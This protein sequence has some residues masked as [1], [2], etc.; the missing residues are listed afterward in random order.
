MEDVGLDISTKMNRASFLSRILILYFAFVATGCSDSKD[1]R[2]DFV[3]AACADVEA[4]QANQS[5]NPDLTLTVNVDNAVAAANHQLGGIGWNAGSLESVQPLRPTFVRVDSNLSSV[6]PSKGSELQLDSLLQKITR[7]RKLGAEPLVILY[8]I[9]AWM[10]EGRAADCTIQ[11]FGGD[12]DPTRVAP[13]D[14][15]EWEDFITRVVRTLATAPDNAVFFEVWNEPDLAFAF[16]QD[17]PQAFLETALRTHRAVERV[18]QE[19]GIDLKIGGPALSGEFQDVFEAVSLEDYVSA[20]TEE[21]L[22][23]DFISWHHYA[24]SPLLGPDGNEGFVDDQL[25]S[26]LSGLNPNT[27]PSVY[28]EMIHDY[29]QRVTALLPQS[30]PIPDLVISEW[31]ISSG[32]LDLRHDT[33]EGA[34]FVTASLIEME[35]ADL[36]SAIIYRGV[37][38]NSPGD[39]GLVR[40]DGSKKPSWHVMHAW[41]QIEGQRL[42]VDG[43]N[44]AAGIWARVVRQGQEIHVLLANFLA[45]EGESS[46]V[47][48]ALQGNCRPRNGCVSLIDSTSKDFQSLQPILFSEEHYRLDLP[49]QSVAWLQLSCDG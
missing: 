34:A 26:A 23:L 21:G 28:L 8:P 40:E 35:R 39:W 3:P 32:G 20:I 10:S 7:I 37:G 48:L 13:D 47:S 44:P 12:C 1:A 30:A 24:N 41:Q 46:L 18:E 19:T 33:H 31:N 2:V 15:D 43:D 25:Y 29:R 9:P 45:V 38:S 22:P 5:V 17:T 27:T 14:L 11:V 16:W 42:A 4:R 6:S 36:S 49:A